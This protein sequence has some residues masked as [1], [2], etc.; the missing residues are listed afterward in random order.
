MKIHDVI[1]GFAIRAVH[2]LSEIRGKLWEMEHVKSGAKLVWLDR[3][4]ENKTFSITFRTLPSDD[5]GVFHILEHSVLCGSQHY[6]VKEPFVELMK[7]SMHTFLNAM[8]FP[9]KT[10]YPVSSRND[11]DFM[12]LLR[13]YMDAVLHPAIY[14]H[15][16]I[17]FQEG[18]HYELDKDGSLVYKGVVLNEMKGVFASPNAIVQ[19]EISRLLFPDT[20][21]RYVS[22]GDPIHIPELTYEQFIEHHRRFYRPDNAYIILDGSVDLELVLNVLDTEYLSAYDRE[23]TQLSIPMQRPIKSVP[24]KA[25]YELPP[26]EPVVGRARLIWGNVLGDFRNREA[27]MVLRALADTLCGSNQ[28]PLKRALLSAKLAQD[29][30][31]SLMDGIQQPVAILEVRNMDESCIAAVEN[32]VQSELKRLCHEGLDHEQL[33]AVLANY[34]FQMRERDYGSMPQ[35]LGFSMDI[36]DSWLYGGNPAAN[37][38]TGKLFTSL[39]RKLEEGWFERL[40]G[41]I[42]MDNPHNCQVLLLPSATLANEKRDAETERLRAVKKSWGVEDISGLQKRQA[43]LIAWQSAADTPEALAALPALQ[44]SDIAVQPERIPLEER[45][46]AG[47][48]L[49]RHDI[50]TGRISYV[51]LYFDVSDFSQEMLPDVSFL[52]RLLGN[53]DTEIHGNLQLQRLCRLNIGR[54]N[55][56]VEAYGGVNAPENCRTFL[57]VSFSAM[58][59][60]LESAA[61]LI[62][63]IITGSKFDD[64]CMIHELL[65]QAIVW[66]EQNIID[67]GSGYAMTR[68]AAGHSAQGVVRE[69]TGGV[70]YFQRLKTLEKNFQRYAAEFSRELAALSKEIFA[71]NRLTISI[72]GT[73]DNAEAILENAVI[74]VLPVSRQKETVCSI[75][76]WSKR[77]EGIVI[78]ADVSFTAMGGNLLQYGGAYNGSLQVLSRIVSLSYLWNVIRVQGGAYG[79]GLSLSNSG[80]ACFYSYRDPTAARSLNAYRQTEGFIKQFCGTKPDLTRFIVGTVAEMDP[81]MLPGRQGKASDR[82]YLTGIEYA[83][84][85]AERREILSTTP[86]RLAAFAQLMYEVSEN[87]S[88][89]VIGSKRQIE[90][91]GEEI[92]SIC[93][94]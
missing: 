1:H 9:D 25:Y 42:F 19:K 10:V 8:T 71:K 29:V 51:N 38:E 65:R 82:W 66:M 69:C 87:G 54:I 68:I 37:L 60:N 80:N 2:E 40:L 36:L 84:Q 56:S 86:E 85:C 89:C 13:V 83:D 6:P 45:T 16:E 58:D 81:L 4:D 34:E 44:L 64:Q 63:E 21:Y 22:G 23:N 55:F 91:C 18:W 50:S 90:S 49:L 74:C 15:P 47:R 12:N 33:A 57:C 46:L 73:N 17:F 31:I 72:T 59:I 67:S 77:R 27:Q 7:S 93:I 78:P 30:R 24:K 48:C 53:M 75:R 5:T 11:K 52:C 32:T 79:T 3:K 43:A 26:D 28:S 62:A 94:L 20:S 41:Q 14:S 35:G 92:D 61:N 88:I 39:N 76:P 70:T